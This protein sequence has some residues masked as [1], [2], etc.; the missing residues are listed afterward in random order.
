[1]VRQKT[2]KVSFTNLGQLVQDVTE[3]GRDAPTPSVGEVD[4]KVT[5]DLGGQRRSVVVVFIAG[6]VERIGRIIIII[7]VNVRRGHRRGHQV[8][9][10]KSASSFFQDGGLGFIDAGHVVVLA[11]VMGV[12]TL[13]EFLDGMNPSYKE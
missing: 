2:Q 11:M 7:I 10:Q 13:D 12:V 4:G 1:M 9:F 8:I 6:I 5:T 3:P